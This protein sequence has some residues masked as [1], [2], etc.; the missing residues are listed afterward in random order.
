MMKSHYRHVPSKIIKVVDND[1][2]EEVDDEELGGNDE[3]TKV[4]LREG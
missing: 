4:N 2:D 1:G 3:G